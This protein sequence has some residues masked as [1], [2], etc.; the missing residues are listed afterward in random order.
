MD[1]DKMREEIARMLDEIRDEYCLSDHE[2]RLVYSDRILSLLA[3]VIE[4][5]EKWDRIGHHVH[6][7]A[8]LVLQ[9]PFYH[10]F[11]VKEVVDIILAETLPKISEV[12]DGN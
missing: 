12:K 3:P 10:D 1:R 9:S 6:G 11:D 4:K 7:L 8:M 5:A 2:S